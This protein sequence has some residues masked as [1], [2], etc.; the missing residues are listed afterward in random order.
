[1]D[2]DLMNGYMVPNA[3]HIGATHSMRQACSIPLVPKKMKLSSS[4][5][6]S[7]SEVSLT[8]PNQRHLAKK[9]DGNKPNLQNNAKR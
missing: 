5:S 3:C 4:S 9:E 7:G 6:T 2:R 8:P 1:M